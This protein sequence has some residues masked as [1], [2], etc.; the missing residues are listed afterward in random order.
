M[1]QSCPQCFNAEKNSSGDKFEQV[2]SMQCIVFFNLVKLS[3]HL[4]KIT[5]IKKFSSNQN[6]E[7]V[8][9]LDLFCKKLLVNQVNFSV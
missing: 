6:L 4:K 2:S 1:D 8:K 7:Q 9:R 5:H 3:T